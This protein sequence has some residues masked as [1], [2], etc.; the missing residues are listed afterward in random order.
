RKIL[1]WILAMLCVKF[2]HG[3]QIY[4]SPRPGSN[5]GTTSFEIIGKYKDKIFI[6]FKK[7]SNRSIIGYDNKMQPIDTVVLDSLPFEMIDL[8]FIN[9]RASFILL[10]QYKKKG[11]V[12]CKAILFDADGK[13]QKPAIVIDKTLHPFKII[14]E[15]AY[16]HAVSED[17][18]KLL[19]YKM[20]RKRND[21][22]L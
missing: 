5:A 13:R 3:Q 6:Y 22:R 21:G 11:D 8:H 15:T 10:Y 4:Y 20:E 14:G 16:S 7:Y 2:S 18:S 9:L 12:I 19:I 17:K 1:L